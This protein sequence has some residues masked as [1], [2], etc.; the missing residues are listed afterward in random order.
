VPGRAVLL[1]G[2]NLRV[3]DLNFCDEVAVLFKRRTGEVFSVG[4]CL[5]ND[6]FRCLND[7]VS[8]GFKF[9]RIWHKKIPFKKLFGAL[10]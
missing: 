7:I 9:S 10:M 5:S 3:K 4:P 8:L 6:F 1:Q 2:L